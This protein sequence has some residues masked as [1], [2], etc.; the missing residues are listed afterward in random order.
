MNAK[1]GLM[2]QPGEQPGEYP[3][4]S[5]RRSAQ[6]SQPNILGPPPDPHPYLHLHHH[7]FTRLPLPLPLPCGPLVAPRGFR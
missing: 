2:T 7:A 5:G 6:S 1:F 3:I 4:L